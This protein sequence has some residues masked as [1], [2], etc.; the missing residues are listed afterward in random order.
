MD[1][2]TLLV[3]ESCTSLREDE[4]EK[5]GG[6][7]DEPE[8]EEAEDSF[9]RETTSSL[10]SELAG[11]FAVWFFSSDEEVEGSSKDDGTKVAERMRTGPSSGSGTVWRD[12][13]GGGRGGEEGTASG[14]GAGGDGREL[15]CSSFFSLSW[16]GT[17]KRAIVF[18]LLSGVFCL[19]WCVCVVSGVVMVNELLVVDEQAF[20]MEKDCVNGVV[21]EAKNE[22]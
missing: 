3:S 10:V 6:A 2:G 22:L 11:L 9:A 19:V 5:G 1:S 15:F 7:E 14:S 4:R 16:A 12:E 21:K 17:E 13:G 20:K 8:M 18:C